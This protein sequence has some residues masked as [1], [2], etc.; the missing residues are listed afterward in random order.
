VH[1]WARERNAQSVEAWESAAS[2]L[3]L[4]IGGRFSWREF[5]YQLVRHLET[6]FAIWQDLAGAITGRLELCRIW[7]AFVWQM[8]RAY[9]VRTLD[10]SS[11]LSEQTQELQSEQPKPLVLA[12]VLF[13]LA[14]AFQQN[15]YTLTA[16]ELLERVVETRRILPEVDPQRLRSQSALAIC[17]RKNAQIPEAIEILEHVVRA[18]KHT[19]EDDIDLLL[20]QHELAL[21]YLGDGQ[22]S[23]A[24]EMLEHV[25]QI[26]DTNLI[27]D[28]PQRLAS[29]QELASAYLND[30]QVSKAIEMLE[31]VV[32]FK[33]QKLADD[34]PSRL[35]AQHE[36]ARAYWHNFQLT[37][38]RDLMER[39]VAIK[40]RTMHADHPERQ[41]PETVLAKII[42]KQG[43]EEAEQAAASV[44]PTERLPANHSTS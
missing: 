30:G 41:V 9:S 38:G 27:E 35:A 17:Y 15:G 3:A 44:D 13:L 31:H 12:Q 34:H 22:T 25:V 40:Q 14:A 42:R 29:Q 21:A 8:Y 6:N 11:Y 24:I 36:L 4:S 32:R 10:L 5:T 1:A 16:I 37:A 43:E 26:R 28:D 19:A 33:E 7:F 2:I 39:V 18:C 23:E 20:S